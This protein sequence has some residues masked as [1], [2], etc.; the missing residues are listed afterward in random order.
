LD[1]V[2]GKL[3]TIESSAYDM[4]LPGRPTPQFDLSE[5]NDTLLLTRLYC[6]GM[7]GSQQQVSMVLSK[8]AGYI[9][10]M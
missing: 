9:G 1:L 6:H 3:K 4:T 5:C 2:S 8:S 7:F 10:K